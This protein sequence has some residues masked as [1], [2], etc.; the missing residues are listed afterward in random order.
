[1]ATITSDGAIRYRPYNGFMLCVAMNLAHETC[2]KTG[3]K[4]VRVQ[5]D[6]QGRPI[7]LK[8]DGKYAFALPGSKGRVKIFDDVT[9]VWI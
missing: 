8:V 3:K 4:S 7:P 1:M 5:Q 2:E 6:Y 9:G